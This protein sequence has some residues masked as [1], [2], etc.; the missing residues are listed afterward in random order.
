M[1]FDP[2]KKHYTVQ[3]TWEMRDERDREWV[4]QEDI[5]RVETIAK[6]QQ[7]VKRRAFMH[8]R[9]NAEIDCVSLSVKGDWA[10]NEGVPMEWLFIGRYLPAPDE[11]EWD[12]A[13]CEKLDRVF[14]DAA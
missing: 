13:G 3:V 12:D 1:N 6:A 11:W 5:I 7:W 10:D 9:P 4:G 14:G 2:N 8:Q